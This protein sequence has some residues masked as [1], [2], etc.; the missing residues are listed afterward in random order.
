[1]ISA[2][3]GMHSQSWA[4]SNPIQRENALPGTQDW[5]L[6]RPALSHEIEGYASLTSVTRGGRIGFYVHTQDPSYSIA[7][8]RMG[9][10]RGDGARLVHGPVTRH[11]VSQPMPSIDPQ[12]G[13]IECAWQDPYILAVGSQ[14]DQEEWTSG[15]YLAK[16]TAGT[17]GAQAYIIFVVRDETRPSDFL[18]QSSVTTYQA[19]NNWGGK[20]L[21]DFNSVGGRAVKV[22]F[23]R[24]YA[25]SSNPAAA[26]GNGAGDFLTNNAVPPTDASSPAGWEYNMVRWLER[27][28]YDVSYSTNIDTHSDARAA[29]PS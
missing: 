8:Y 10:Y 9:W 11:A 17:S 19:Y 28:G 3:S 23:N 25:V 26:Y 4:E 24:P 22:T 14:A 15:I 21:Y 7:I 6:T 29:G 20:S 12:T 13:L 18:F 16:L 1:M 27:E 5:R 2:V